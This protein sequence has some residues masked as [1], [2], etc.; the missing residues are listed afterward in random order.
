[1]MLSKLLY[2]MYSLLWFIIPWI[3]KRKPLLSL[4]YF[5]LHLTPI[6]G[7]RENKNQFEGFVELSGFINKPPHRRDYLPGPLVLSFMCPICA[8]LT[9]SLRYLSTFPESET[10]GKVSVF[11]IYFL[12][13]E[14]LVQVG[15]WQSFCCFRIAWNIKG[16]PY[17]IVTFL[18]QAR[19]EWSQLSKK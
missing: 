15:E 1:M 6:N 8:V 5:T 2:W 16:S 19:P 4:R 13:K 7:K 10:I 9:G 3:V 11:V 18:L 17:A 14:Q 12:V